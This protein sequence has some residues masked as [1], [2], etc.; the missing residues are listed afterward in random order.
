MKTLGV[1]Y[2][3]K[4]ELKRKTANRRRGWDKIA[5]KSDRRKPDENCYHQARALRLLIPLSLY[6]SVQG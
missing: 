6:L 1:Y 2:T 5:K 3:L 4:T